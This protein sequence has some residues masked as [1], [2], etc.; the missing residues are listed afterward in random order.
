MK[1]ILDYCIERFSVMAI[2]ILGLLLAAF[3]GFAGTCS[4]L[5]FENFC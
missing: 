1:K 2:F 3:L 5:K 4:N